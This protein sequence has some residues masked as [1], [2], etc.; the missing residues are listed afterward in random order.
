MLKADDEVVAISNQGCP[1]PKSRLHLGFK[2][3][4]EYIVEIQV[5]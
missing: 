4:V 1:A 3:Q 5:T 2:P